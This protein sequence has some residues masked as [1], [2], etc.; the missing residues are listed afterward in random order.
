[1]TALHELFQD[2]TFRTWYLIV[3]VGVLWVPM[4]ALSRWYH[5]NIV[6]TSGG[7]KLM[8]QQRFTP[9]HSGNLGQGMRMARDIRRGKYGSAARSMQ[10]RTYWIVAVW[11]AA[12]AVYFGL[13][14]WADEMNR[15][16][17]DNA[18]PSE[19]LSRDHEQQ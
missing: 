19:R 2:E 1:M 4:I 8:E 7:R 18:A 14:I 9:A 5:T 12:L 16:E 10:N 3:G 17:T 15:A 13:L 6:K 11:V